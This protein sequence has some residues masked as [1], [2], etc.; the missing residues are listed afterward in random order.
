M[1]DERVH[2]ELAL[3][4]LIESLLELS[5]ASWVTLGF[6]EEVQDS[7]RDARNIRA[8]AALARHKKFVRGL[9]RDLDWTSLALR[10]EQFRAGQQLAGSEGSLP[11]HVQRAADLVIQG[12]R[13][14]H[15]FVEEFPAANRTRLWQLIRNVKGSAEAKRPRARSVLEQAVLSAMTA[16]PAAEE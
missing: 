9:L 7:L 10:T 5:E 16:G 4:E 13:G 2:N 12:E 8:P 15:R 1:K 6:P 14:L 11:I 3:T